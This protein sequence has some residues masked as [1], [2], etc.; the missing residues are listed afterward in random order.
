M[1]TEA[2]Y[3]YRNFKLKIQDSSKCKKQRCNKRLFNDPK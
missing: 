1:T 3:F 2:F